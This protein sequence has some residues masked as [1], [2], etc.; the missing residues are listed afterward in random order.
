MKSKEAVKSRLKADSE[1]NH[2]EAKRRKLEDETHQLRLE[3]QEL[4]VEYRVRTATSKYI[5]LTF[6]QIWLAKAQDY[7]EKVDTKRLPGTIRK[8][9][10]DMERA[11]Q[12]GEAE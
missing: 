1:K 8:E 11:L 6:F 5:Q 9:I 3:C 12:A 2:W 4:E 10:G 7:C